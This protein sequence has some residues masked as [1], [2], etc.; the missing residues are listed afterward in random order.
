MINSI[1]Y[2]V[3]DEISY[4]LPKVNLQVLA[5]IWCNTI[6]K[7]VDPSGAPFTNME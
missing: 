4:S 3:W 6:A 5:D 7:T 1:H 2:K